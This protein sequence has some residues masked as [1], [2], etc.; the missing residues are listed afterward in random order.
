MRVKQIQLS[1]SDYLRINRERI[2]QQ[3]AP[4]DPITG[5]GSTSVERIHVQISDSPIGTDL[6]L[7]KT[8][9]EYEAVAKLVEC[10]SISA[11][12]ADGGLYDTEENKA[13][14]WREFVRLRIQHDFEYW[15]VSFVVIQDKGSGCDIPFKLNRGQRK[16]LAR[17]ERMRLKG[18]PIR[19]ILLKARQWGGSTLTQIYIAWLQLVLI[20]SWSSVICAHTENTARN[21]RGMYSKLLEN[22]P[23][24]LVNTDDRNQLKLSNYENSQ[25]TRIIKCR[26]CK[27]SIGSA[28]KPDGL[29][30]LD[31]A[32]A[33]LSE[34]GLFPST[35]QTKPEDLV[36]S[37]CSGISNKKNT[38]IV[39][40]ST[41]KGVGN[42]FH[43]E[44]K[45]A[46][47]TDASERSNFDPVFV[48]WFEIDNYT[49]HIDD[50]IEFVKSL[51]DEEKRMFDDGATLEGIAWHRAK[52]A[53]YSDYWRFASE[54]PSTPDEAFQSTGHPYYNPDDV[55]RL[56]AT[57]CDPKYIGEITA[58]GEFGSQSAFDGIRFVPNQRGGLKIW[59]MPEP[60]EQVTGRYVVVVD[61]GGL[62]EKSDRSVICVLDRYAMAQG[63]VPEVVAEWCGHTPHYKL[64]WQSAQIAM[65]YHE[66]LL[67]IESNTPDSHK[68]EGVHSEFIMDEISNF[69]TNLYC[70]TSAEQVKQGIPA[71]YGFHTNK[72]TKTMVCD[73]QRKA[74]EHDMYIE[75]CI[76]AVYEHKTLEIKT[77]GTIGATDGNHDDRHITRAIGVWVCYQYLSPPVR[78]EDLATDQIWTPKTTSSYASF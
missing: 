71:K 24:W 20:R 11:T 32:C 26:G 45:R 52:R 46:T 67:V 4:Y 56:E 61:I 12:L 1:I 5:K 8:M 2:E 72:L 16:L 21:V 60:K 29:R 10:G 39:Y 77:N 23:L 28:T 51:T 76:D 31:V 44:W 54:Y 63:G 7:P 64:A 59:R 19:V 49:A 40:E 68:T 57:C 9:L 34:I 69:Y 41:A 65:W 62:S 75:R 37:V 30:G 73:H 74:L 78:Y 27:V 42:F 3:R 70:R 47:T 14:F 36:Q 15:A 33:H 66:A 25:K 6:W 58:N 53:E 18:L 38:I 13:E 50:Y 43:R 48:A 17:F 55:K 22:Y 35:L